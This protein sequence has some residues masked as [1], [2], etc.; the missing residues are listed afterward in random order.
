MRPGAVGSWLEQ[1]H[2]GVWLSRLLTF[3]QTNF[4]SGQPSVRLAISSW[5]CNEVSTFVFPA[6]NASIA[7]HLLPL[8]E[9]DQATGPSGARKLLL[10]LHTLGVGTEWHADSARDQHD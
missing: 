8:V 2:S 5:G 10:G 7:V 3:R 1:P 4:V 6:S 9:V